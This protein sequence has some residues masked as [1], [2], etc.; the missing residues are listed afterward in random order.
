[1]AQRNGEPPSA[2]G[3][4][5]QR[6][7]RQ[8][9]ASDR[10]A[11]DD[12]PLVTGPSLGPI[13][14]HWVAAIVVCVGT[15]LGV[16]DNTIT[17]IALDTLTT[18]FDRPLDDVIWVA[19]AFIVVSTGL[20]LTMGRM[21]DLYGR[22]RLYAWGYVLFTVATLLS[23]IAGSLEEL[24]GSRVLQAIGA[25]MTMANGAA[26]ITAAFPPSKRGTGLGLIVSTVGAGAAA[27]PILG[28][29]LIDLLD[30]R[31]IFWTRV[32]FGLIAAVL[33]WRLLVDAPSEQRP[34]GLD[35]PGAILLFGML[36]CL[37]FGINRARDLGITST[38]VT[39]V[40]AAGLVFMV[41]FIIVERRSPSPVVDLG[42]FKGRGFSF[43]ILAAILQ[44][45]GLS[46]TFILGPIVLQAGRGFSPT[47]TAM[48][49]MPLS[50]MML[51]WSPI[52]GRLSD[53]FGSRPLTTAG[54]VIV[55][56]ALFL[57][58]RTTADTSPVDFAMRMLLLGIGTSTFSSPN[59]SVIMSAVPPER[60]GTASASQTTARTFGNAFGTSVGVAIMTSVAA[61]FA[62]DHG[63]AA[64][65]GEAVMQGFRAALVVAALAASPAI[66]FSLFGG[67]RGVRGVAERAAGKAVEGVRVVRVAIEDEISGMVPLFR[68]QKTAIG[69]R[70]GRNGAEGQPP[71]AVGDTETQVRS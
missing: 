57:L 54:M 40:I 30:W 39:V 15:F 12:R 62:L 70:D 36:A 38:L 1:M 17:N 69:P 4:S 23:S 27:G 58:S 21:G 20:S 25:A 55:C 56:L 35:V 63:V 48:M 14:Y 45:F 43:G 7:E 2:F 13:P 52:S 42:L 24:V 41:W 59:T 33:A 46:F 47:E 18:E 67:Q 50:L 6:G 65:S 68:G 9:R 53:R 29:V 51:L 37:T 31:A 44:F 10:G 22:K 26:I 49:M 8:R 5:P 3:S 61:S 11:S 19:L 64:E 32:P 66:L 34:K 28:G 71:L 16:M 60:L